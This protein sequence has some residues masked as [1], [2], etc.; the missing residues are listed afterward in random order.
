[1]FDI[2]SRVMR[3]CISLGFAAG[4]FALILMSP[5]SALAVDGRTAV[6]MCIDSTASGARCGWSVNDKGEIDICNKSG[7]VYCPSATSECTAAAKGR[8]RPTIGLPEGTKVI[9]AVGTFQI[10]PRA[11]NGSLLGA[12]P[13]TKLPTK[14][15]AESCPSGKSCCCT[16]ITA[17]DCVLRP[18][19]GC[20]SDRPIPIL[21][22]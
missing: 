22:P 9:T 12:V 11:I 17:D 1:M 8:P 15:Q 6:G 2:N 4:I 21:Q 5:T 13:K 14:A 3:Q 18:S 16:S 19:T 7:C 10:K 20:G